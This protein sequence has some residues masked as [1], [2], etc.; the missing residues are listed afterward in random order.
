MSK[1]S[2]II[3]SKDT[4]NDCWKRGEHDLLKVSSYSYFGIVKEPGICI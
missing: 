2:V 4:V 3:F 1:S